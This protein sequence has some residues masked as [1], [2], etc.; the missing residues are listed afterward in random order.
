MNFSLTDLPEDLRETIEAVYRKARKINPQLTEVEFFARIFCNWLKPYSK[1][2]P[3]RLD[4][5]KV[6]LRNRLEELLTVYD[7]SRAQLARKTGIS[8]TYIGRIIRQEYTPTITVAYL[9]CLAFGMDISK[10]SEIFYL[11]PAE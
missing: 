9:I 1:V 8:S 5:R 11:E 10:V 3:D 7:I 4:R 6:I 2:K